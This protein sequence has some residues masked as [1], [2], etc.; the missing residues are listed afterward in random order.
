V[1]NQAT[2][3]PVLFTFTRFYSRRGY[4]F[5]TPRPVLIQVTF[6]LVVPRI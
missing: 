4:A 6:R 5:N 2:V 3:Q 1:T